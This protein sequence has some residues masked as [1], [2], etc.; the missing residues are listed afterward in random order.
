MIFRGLS[1]E[2]RLELPPEARAYVAR[3][4]GEPLFVEITPVYSRRTIPQNR[5]LWAGYG[6][7][8][9]IAQTLMPYTKDELHDALKHRSEVVKPA[10]L[11]L[12]NGE[13]LGTARSTKSLNVE[14]FGD[15]MEEV[16][17]TFAR[18]GIDIYPE[19]W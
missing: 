2:G 14:Q 15:Y 6:R 11:Y 3:F 19:E 4:G 5:R 18:G 9:K 1:V 8:L 13:A 16:S 10:L 17:A 12:P 7:A